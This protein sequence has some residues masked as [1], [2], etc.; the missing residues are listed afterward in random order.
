MAPNIIRSEDSQKPVRNYPASP[1]RLFE[2]LFNDWALR[3]MDDRRDE[4]W[5]PSVDVMEK[6]GTMTLMASLP[7]MT[8]KDIELKV[9]G[10]VLTIKGERKSPETAGF[11]Y[12][13]RESRSG[14]FSRSFTLPDSAN[15]ENIRADYKNGILTIAVP[16]KPEAKSRT[17]KVNT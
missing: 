12:Y 17:I 8:E 9:E 5:T 13:Q 16:Q 4:S 15:L 7:G 3:S 14:T 10:Q 2:D 6:D 11:T 1:F